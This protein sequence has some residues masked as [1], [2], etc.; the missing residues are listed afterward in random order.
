MTKGPILQEMWDN[1]PEERKTR[2]MK[3]AAELEEEYLTLQDLRKAQQLTQEHMAKT[4]NIGQE[5]ISRLEKRSD[6]MLSTLRKY[7]KAMGGD[8]KIMAEFPNRS[9][10]LLT[11]I[12]DFIDS[13][14]DE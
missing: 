1:L 6:M 2:I 12:S 9:P 10:V 4:L 11:G 8:L 5:N 7:V 3:Q 13:D 14:K